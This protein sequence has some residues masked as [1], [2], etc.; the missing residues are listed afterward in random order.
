P[1]SF[2]SFPRKRESSLFVTWTPAFAG[3]T[4]KN[5]RRHLP[6]FILSTVGAVRE[7]PSHKQYR[8][9]SSLRP[10]PP[11]SLL[12]LFFVLSLSS[13]IPFSSVIPAKAGIQVR[14]RFTK[15][16]DP[17]FRGGDSKEEPPSSSIRSFRSSLRL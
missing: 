10:E 15:S 13:V 16:L 5:S 4:R 9:P 1:G 8:R 7:T 6:V 3:V 12:S 14:F 11:F 2:P 17:R